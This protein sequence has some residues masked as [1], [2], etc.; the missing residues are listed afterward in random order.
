M[1][2]KYDPNRAH[3]ES[4][5]KQSFDACDE[6]ASKL[7]AATLA[8]RMSFSA[9]LEFLKEGCMLART[10]WNGRGMWIALQRPDAGS[11]NTLPYLFM[12]TA[13]SQRVPWLASQTDLLADDWYVV[14]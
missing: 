6:T 8:S 5:C 2:E 4:P 13:Q 14:R 7:G 3:P 1:D 12:H 9:A 10:G 11:K